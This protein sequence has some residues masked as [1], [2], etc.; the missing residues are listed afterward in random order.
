MKPIPQSLQPE[1]LM[2]HMRVLCKE[3]PRRQPTRKG[4]RMAAEY[5]VSA[6]NAMG[7]GDP[8]VEKF[9]G[10]P[11]LGLPALLT[12]AM[13]L[14]SLPLGAYCGPVGKIV[15]GL[16]LF[17]ASVTFFQLLSCRPP[18]FHKIIERWDSQN[19]VKTIP[20]SGKANGHIYLIGHLDANKQ[21]FIFPPPW[22]A[23]MKIMETSV[24]ILAAVTGASFWLSAILGPNAIWPWVWLAAAASFLAFALLLAADEFQPTIEGANDN[25]TAVSL[26]LGVGEALKAKPLENADVTLLFTGCEEVGNHGMIAY[27]DAHKPPKEG[28]YWID[29]EMVGTG[30]IAYATKHG[31]SYL[32]EYWPGAEILGYAERTAKENPDL[33]V[34]GK[35]M[36]ILEE[37]SPLRIRDYDA[38]CVLGYDKEGYLPH[39]HRT[40]DTLENIEPET[41]SRAARYVHALMESINAGLRR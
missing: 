36:L 11:T 33:R 20:A 24:V 2:K 23:L 17:F 32:T 22:P 35:D 3:L 30:N 37:V 26:L 14:A 25:A 1:Q 13:C 7:L 31:I 40:S 39:W 4:E 28:T 41:L 19:V 34:T 10:I 8:A 6:L 15:A 9:K 5:V 12:S 18:L 21:R 27:L 38:L 29:V 16:V